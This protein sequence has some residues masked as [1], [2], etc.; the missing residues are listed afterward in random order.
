IEVD[1]VP[2][3]H[4]PTAT[5]CIGNVLGGDGAVELATLADLDAHRQGRAADALCCDLGVFPL[6]LAL[7]LAAGDVVLPRAVCAAC[8]RYGEV[9]L[10][11]EVSCV[12]IGDILELAALSERADVLGE[13]DLHAGASS[14][15][16]WVVVLDTAA[17]CRRRRR[18][19][20]RRP[21]I[22]ARLAMIGSRRRALRTGRGSAP[23]AGP[24]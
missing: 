17:I 11:Q 8:R 20:S 4:D 12:P 16:W 15:R 5:K 2:I 18:L 9:L 19:T 24:A 7:L 22:M 21:R 10:D 1:L 13:N 6:A 3:D 14:V 23:R